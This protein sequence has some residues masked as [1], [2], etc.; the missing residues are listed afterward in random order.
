MVDRLLQSVTTRNVRL[1]RMLSVD[2]DGSRRS[3]PVSDES[4]QLPQP[5]LLARSLYQNTYGEEMP[6]ALARLFAM[7]KRQSSASDAVS[8]PF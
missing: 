8:S 7:A 3:Y 1:C 4:L 2:A 6:D 5:A